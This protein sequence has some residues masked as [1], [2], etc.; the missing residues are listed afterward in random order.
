[1]FLDQFEKFLRDRFTGDIIE[2]LVQTFL[3]PGIE[4]FFSRFF[5]PWRIGRNCGLP[6][7]HKQDLQATTVH[8]AAVFTWNLDGAAAIPSGPAV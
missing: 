6:N 5:Y 1:M 2:N 3:K 8:F 7:C 4:R